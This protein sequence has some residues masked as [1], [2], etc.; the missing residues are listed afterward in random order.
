MGLEQ[1]IELLSRVGLFQDF[2]MEQLRLIAFGTER[3]TART[4]TFLFRESE[5]AK[6]GYVVAGGQIDIVLRRG[7][8]DI[9]LQNCRS[10][11]LIGEMALIT[12]TRR[13][14]SAVAKVNSDVLFIPRTLFHRLLR[15]YPS[16]AALLHSRIAHSVRRLVQEMDEVNIRLNSLPPM[17][18][19]Q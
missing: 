17:K 13:A 3:E 9:V 11:A 5:V 4:G 10:A 6:G 7:N 19:A 16:M 15:E 2:E 14:T 8:T 1:D 18:G 12:E